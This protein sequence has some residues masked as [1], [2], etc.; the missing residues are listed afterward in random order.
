MLTSLKITVG[1][2]CE[3]EYFFK[4]KIFHLMYKMTQNHVLPE[5]MIRAIQ[6]NFEQRELPV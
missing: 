4:T 5:D 3:C 6:A 2:F 1:M